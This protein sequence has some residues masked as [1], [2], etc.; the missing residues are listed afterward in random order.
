MAESTKPI[1]QLF[2]LYSKN[3][4]LYNPDLE[5]LFCCPLCLRAFGRD[6]LPSS[7]SN[8]H[9]SIEHIIPGSIG[10]NVTTLT[11]RECNNQH[12]TDLDA[13]IAAR[14]KAEDAFA[15][16]TSKPL[17][18]RVS[19]GHGEMAVD[20]HWGPDSVVMRGVSRASSPARV[21]ALESEL[22]VASDGSEIHLNIPL[23][24]RLL[25]SQ[26]AILRMAYLLMFRQ[27]G[28]GYIFH[29]NLAQIREQINDIE[30]DR[31]VSRALIRLNSRPPEG[32]AV[33]VLTVPKELRCFFVMF[34]LSSAVERFVGVVMPGLDQSDQNVYESWQAF[35][36]RGGG[37]F[38]FKYLPYDTEILQ[39]Q[40]GFPAFLWKEVT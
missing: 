3:L 4:A 40:K 30:T 22:N 10:G 13:H 34:D 37:S 19:I 14:F 12:G 6:S 28:Y 15:G 1:Q 9:I 20:V 17:K 35:A 31:I 26:L 38:H 33:T 7:D 24:Y 21:I 23:G 8:G 11:C 27:F 16:K 39:T 29:P 36:P 5:N 2:E 25:N 18:G 32:F